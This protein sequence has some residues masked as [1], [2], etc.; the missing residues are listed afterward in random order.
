MD[1]EGEQYFRA[2]PPGFIWKGK[3]SLFKAHDS[4]LEDKGNLSIYLFG[5]LRIAKNEGEELNQAELLRWLGESVWM[6]TNLLPSENKTWT[7]LTDTSSKITFTYKGLDV[8]YKVYFNELG[9]IT[10]L[11]TERYMD[12]KLE[13]WNGEVGH[14]EEKNGMMVPMDITASWLLEDGKYT[15][16]RFHVEK[17]EYNKPEKF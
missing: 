5:F 14:Y 8:Y 16:A 6:P 11:E 15:Y 3:T 2:N 10:S 4:Y 12:G 17:F 13:K 7:A 1:I 9:Q